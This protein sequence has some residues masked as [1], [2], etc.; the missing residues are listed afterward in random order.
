MLKQINRL[1][2]SLIL[3]ILIGIVTTLPANAAAVKSDGNLVSLVPSSATSPIFDPTKVRLGITPTGWSNSD[4]PSID[5]V[6]PIPYQ[7]ILSEMALSGFKGSQ[8]SGKYPQ[9]MNVLKKE[10]GLR[11]TL[12]FLNLGWELISLLMM[13]QIAKKSSMNRWNL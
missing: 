2:L 3:V 11:G 10:L 6:P 4:D 8:M 5:L 7:Q 12:L 13:T 1:L 9:D